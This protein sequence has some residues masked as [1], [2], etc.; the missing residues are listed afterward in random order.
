MQIALSLPPRRGLPSLKYSIHSINEMNARFVF[1]PSVECHLRL[2]AFRNLFG[3]FASPCLDFPPS[4]EFRFSQS[5]RRKVSLFPNYLLYLHIVTRRLLLHRSSNQ[6]R[7]PPATA[8]PTDVGPHF[9]NGILQYILRLIEEN[10]HQP[11]NIHHQCSETVVP[12]KTYATNNKH[13]G[14]STRGLQQH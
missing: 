5:D 10:R 8:E 14:C 13:Y 1:L 2:I 11:I 4:Y 12:W 3:A 7:T 9:V 6:T